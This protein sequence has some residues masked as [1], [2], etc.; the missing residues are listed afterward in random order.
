MWTSDANLLYILSRAFQKYKS[1]IKVPSFDQNL[2]FLIA[3]MWSDLTT[4][5]TITFPF[6]RV[7][8]RIWTCPHYW[9]GKYRN[10]NCS[11]SW[12]RFLTR[13]LLSWDAYMFLW[14]GVA[15]VLNQGDHASQT[16]RGT[17]QQWKNPS[18][19][20]SRSWLLAA[21]EHFMNGSAFGA[22]VRVSWCW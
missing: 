16:D 6:A 21:P 14:P 22:T 10:E 9:L 11:S 17:E 19:T 7:C 3:V 5:L 13:W 12:K 20:S 8:Y 2:V 4:P 18:V 15:L 1:A